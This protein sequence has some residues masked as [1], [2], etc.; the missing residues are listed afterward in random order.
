MLRYFNAFGPRQ[1][2]DMAFPRIVDALAAGEP[3]ELFGDGEQSR[4]FT[5]VGDVV[6]ATIAA[7][8]RAP[9][10]RSTTS[11]AAPRRRCTTTIALLE[12][13]AGRELD[14]RREPAVPGDQRRTKADTTRIRAELGWE[15]RSPLERR[16][17]RP[18]GMGRG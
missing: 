17:A 7:M 12:R 3:F 5:Y 4:G 18:V 13:V 15:P 11:A 10:A 16:A 1:R 2:P 8:E 14:V 9:T 6:E